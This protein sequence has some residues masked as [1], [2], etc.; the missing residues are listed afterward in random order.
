[1]SPLAAVLAICLWVCQA[2]PGP[3]TGFVPPG[4]V[5]NQ[6]GSCLKDVPPDNIYGC[7]EQRA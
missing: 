6:R 7:P 2:L 1:M 3:P 5:Y 4:I